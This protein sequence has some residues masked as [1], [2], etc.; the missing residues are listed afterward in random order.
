M[1]LGVA[2]VFVVREGINNTPVADWLVA[3]LGRPDTGGKADV[4]VVLGAGLTALCTPNAYSLQRVLL[5]AQLFHD[6]RAPVVLFTGGRP[7]GSTCA[8]SEVMQE[9]AVRLGVP[10]DQIR[11][12]A[13]STSTWQNAVRSDA[14]LE[15]AGGKA[16]LARHGPQPYASGRGELPPIRIRHRTRERSHTNR[17]PGQRLGAVD[18]PAGVRR[19]GLLPLARLRQ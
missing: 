6:G 14:V 4:M 15:Y 19:R 17:T 16:N 3:P 7:A 18:G 8:V 13:S 9:L 2:L 1:V 11:V 5:A 10:A 12:E